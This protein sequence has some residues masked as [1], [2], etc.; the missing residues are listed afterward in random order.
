MP[1]ERVGSILSPNP[2]ADSGKINLSEKL[3]LEIPPK[4]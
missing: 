1:H 2:A 3:L 4:V